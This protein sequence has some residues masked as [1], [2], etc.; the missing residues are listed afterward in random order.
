MLAKR[1]AS[2]PSTS[3]AITA[4]TAGEVSTT[5]APLGLQG[6]GE[7]K[8]KLVNKS[9]LA[10]CDVRVTKTESDCGDDLDPGIGV[11]KNAM[12]TTGDGD[13]DSG[14]GLT[15]PLLVT[16][17]EAE[18]FKVQRPKPFF[19][20][21]KCEDD[22]ADTEKSVLDPSATRDVFAATA[23]KPLFGPRAGG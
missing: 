14:I 22:E 18:I 4:A 7:A 12:A 19:G 3:G 10:C 15:V 16:H 17:F 21:A 11:T 13:V 9:E 20:A 1:G 8:L 5:S 6:I 23:P 2:C